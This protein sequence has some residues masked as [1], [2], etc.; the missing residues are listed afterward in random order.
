MKINNHKKNVNQNSQNNLLKLSNIIHEKIDEKNQYCNTKIYNIPW[1]LKYAVKTYSYYRV[2][3]VN[4]RR[5]CPDFKFEYRILYFS[6]LGKSCRKVLLYLIRNGINC[7]KNIYFN[8]QKISNDLNLK[9]HQVKYSLRRLETSGYIKRMWYRKFKTTVTRFIMTC[10]CKGLPFLSPEEKAKFMQSKQARID[11]ANSNNLTTINYLNT[12]NKNI[13]PPNK[14]PTFILRE[15]A[16]DPKPTQ[17]VVVNI[18]KKHDKSYFDRQVRPAR[19]QEILS[20]AKKYMQFKIENWRAVKDRIHFTQKQLKLTVNQWEAIFL[21][22][23][24]NP[25][26]NGSMGTF[27][28]TVDFLVAEMNV[29]KIL[30]NFYKQFDNPNANSNTTKVSVVD[31]DNKNSYLK[32]NVCR[33]Q[34][35][36]QF[37]QQKSAPGRLT[38]IQP[39]LNKNMERLTNKSQNIT[40]HNDFKKPNKLNINKIW[41]IISTSVELGLRGKERY[42]YI[43]QEFKKLNILEEVINKIKNLGIF[44]NTDRI[45]IDKVLQGN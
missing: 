5:D 29:K 39:I 45:V 3:G 40:N 9:Y 22:A 25:F 10:V 15:M 43:E 18:N 17:S 41:S 38:P 11:N 16:P 7:S 33:E 2:D 30:G 32:E 12:K 6:D 23:S 27:K 8:L 28:A 24:K 36:V 34:N 14:K 20:I 13:T 42:D 21:Y 26:L 1:Q 31:A 37:P 35:Q 44:F 4:R 19:N